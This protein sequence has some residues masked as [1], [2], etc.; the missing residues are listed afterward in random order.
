M[1]MTTNRCLMKSIALVALVCAAAI[2]QIDGA[3]HTFSK[4]YAMAVLDQGGDANDVE[5]AIYIEPLEA[6][7]SRIK[8]APEFFSLDLHPFLT[9]VSSDTWYHRPCD[10][11]NCTQPWH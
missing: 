6:G 7:G 8:G 9:R 3:A 2:G 11:Q 10:M 4:Q 5:G 1:M